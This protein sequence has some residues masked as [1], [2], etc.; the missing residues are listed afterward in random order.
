M[1]IVID[2]QGMQNGSRHRGI[3][4]YSL[5]FAKALIRNNRNHEI[6]IVLSHLFPDFIE[7]VEAEFSGEYSVSDIKVWEGVGPTNFLDTNSDHRRKI[8]QISRE[9]FIASLEPD[10]LIVSS[11]FEGAGDNS[12]TSVGEFCPVFTAVILYDLIPLIYGSEYLADINVN[13]W[14]QDKV[15]QLKRAD[16]WLAISE[17]SREEGFNYLNLP[18]DKIENIS[19]AVG[20]EFKRADL[21]IVEKAALHKKFGINK[22]FLMYSGATDPRKNI[23]RLINAYAIIDPALRNNHQLV[24][25]GGLPDDHREY[26]ERHALKA[27]LKS[28]EIVLT[29]RVTDAEMIGLYST[30]KAFILPSY[31]EGFGLPALEAMACGAP[32]IGSNVSSI[33][34]VIGMESALFDPRSLE[35][36]AQKINKVLSDEEFRNELIAH[37]LKQAQFFCWDRTANLTFD[38]LES[39]QK[40][41]RMPPR[42]SFNLEALWPALMERLADE[43][44]GCATEEDLVACATSISKALPKAD[45]RPRLYI[46]ISELHRRDSRTGIQRVVRSIVGCLLRDDISSYKIELVY[47]NE[48]QPYKIAT[49]YQ[50]KLENTTSWLSPEADEIIDPRGGDIF[51]G[52]DYQD[53]IVFAHEH[54]YETLRQTGIK[55]YFVVYDLLP[56]Q[57]TNIFSSEVSHN[58]KRWLKVVA[59]QDGVICISH[60]VAEEFTKWASALDRKY[61][62]PLTVNAFHLG[63]D[64]SSSAPSM[65][66]P[67]NADEILGNIAA[68]HCFVSVG[69]LEPRK[70]QA[71]ILDACEHLWAKGQD[72]RLVL[73]GKQGWMVDEL[74]TKIRS[75]SELGKR[76]FWLE[77]I[78]DEFLEKVYAASTC[79]IAA[80]HGEGFGLPLIE[81]AQHKLPIIARDIPVF[82]EVAGEHAF[83]FQGMSAG[84]L[85]QAIEAWLKL[86]EVGEYP[87]SM[88]MPWLTWEESAQQL[89]GVLLGED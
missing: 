44:V 16:L 40:D 32:T 47:A 34:E 84:S 30:C 88:T 43:S 7:A 71:Q 31:H 8:S 4:R 73:I 46:D 22:Q 60:T 69:T 17:S 29:G 33:P 35:D 11:I 19:A 87:T 25:A 56:I 86:F 26:L 85:A 89:K 77:G 51:L 18:L 53:Q 81:A 57:L 63:A 82:R 48:T 10:V 20:P 74:I 62:L 83:Y 80:S 61:R 28:R 66:V 13:N 9:F 50:S 72:L 39:M 78:S 49:A 6:I 58:Y 12:V 70:G 27:S 79:L 14:Y 45:P 64:I 36:I 75:H 41:G 67:E 52:L 55:V 1:R 42:R 2:L 24:L 3:G 37:G 65:G 59:E 15:K 76:L 68:G 38:R 23:D 54:F 21:G 5:S